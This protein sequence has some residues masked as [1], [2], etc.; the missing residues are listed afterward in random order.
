MPLTKLQIDVL[1]LTAADGEDTALR[2]VNEGAIDDWLSP[3]PSKPLLSVRRF[4]KVDGGEIRVA[5]IHTHAMGETTAAIVA[6]QY[7]KQL[8]PG[9]LAMCGVCA[10]RPGWTQLGD[11]VI[12]EHLFKYDAGAALQ[13]PGLPQH[14]QP[15]G[16]KRDLP[17]DWLSHAQILKT[18]FP[19]SEVGQKLAAERPYPPEIAELWLLDMLSRSEEPKFGQAIGLKPTSWRALVERLA[20]QKQIRLAD[21]LT[22]M[23]KGQKRLDRQLIVDPDPI[24]PPA[25]QIHVAPFGT[26]SALQRS[27]G[28][29]D[30]LGDQSRLVRALDMEGAAIGEAGW[31]AAIEPTLVVKGVMDFAEPGRSQHVRE[32]AAKAAAEVLLALLRQQLPHRGRTVDDVL[33]S[34]TNARPERSINPGALF[35]PRHQ[36]IEFIDSVRA[37][38]L[39]Q[40]E[41]WCSAETP[42]CG[43]LFYG[44]GGTGKT[45]LMIEWSSRLRTT[46]WHA[47]FLPEDIPDADLDLVLQSS[48]PTLFIVDYA[49]ARPNLIAL[50]KK[51]ASA[52]PKVCGKLRVLLLAREVADWWKVLRSADT[53]IEDL[54]GGFAP[55]PVTVMPIVGPLRMR[56]FDAAFTTFARI[57]QRSVPGVNPELADGRFGRALCVAMAALAAVEGRP[58][59]AESI[60]ADTVARE[61]HFWSRRFGRAPCVSLVCTLKIHA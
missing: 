42:A 19:K 21:K 25:W 17:K 47:G 22:I 37:Q 61:R 55:T 48:G 7:I 1:V 14:F 11:V 23:A 35:H 13:L 15:E 49:E 39:Q 56:L 32:F 10:G 45:R 29:W 38:E 18:A 28:I 51:A 36:V 60:L 20:D 34:G 40:L 50:M 3:D 31:H 2:A 16:Q 52:R 46:G 43:R 8:L 57:L 5:H 59:R 53:R 58:I 6:T 24:A 54:F 4:R 26:G 12:A 41:A 9:A 30:R 27:A 33:L 44:P